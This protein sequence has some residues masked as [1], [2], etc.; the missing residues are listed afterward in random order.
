M[1]ICMQLWYRLAESSYSQDVF[2]RIH[3][4]VVSHCIKQGGFVTDTLTA[5]LMRITR[6]IN[7]R[8]YGLRPAAIHRSAS[9]DKFVHLAMDSER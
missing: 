3:R 5:F 8:A 9:T 7:Y 2:S 1:N 6:N 4:K